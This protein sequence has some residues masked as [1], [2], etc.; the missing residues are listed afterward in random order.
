M[1]VGVCTFRTF[2]ASLNASKHFYLAVVQDDIP[3]MKSRM[4]LLLSFSL[5]LHIFLQEGMNEEHIH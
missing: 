2:T 5:F 3:Q 1:C 4:P